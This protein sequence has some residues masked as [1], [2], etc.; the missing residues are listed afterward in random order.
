MLEGASWREERE[1]NRMAW[2]TSHL[3]NVSG[4]TLRRTVTPNE[5]LGR[6]REVEVKDPVGQFNELWSRLQQRK[7]EEEERN[8]PDGEADD[9]S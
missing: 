7:R 1:W 6:K 2:Q 9:G 8:N 5:L 3:L 4:K